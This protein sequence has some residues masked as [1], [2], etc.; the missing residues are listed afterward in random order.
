[1]NKSTSASRCAQRHF[2]MLRSDETLPYAKELLFII[3]VIIKENHQTCVMYS[4]E[5]IN[6]DEHMY[7]E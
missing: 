5:Q 1:M 6:Q 2:A 3:K 7:Q 4:L